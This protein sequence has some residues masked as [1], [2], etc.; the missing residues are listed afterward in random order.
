MGAE[1]S[2]CRGNPLL[3]HGL[4]LAIARAFAL[5]LVLALARAAEAGAAAALRK[6]VR[7][8]LRREDLEQSATATSKRSHVKQSPNCC[9]GNRRIT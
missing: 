1:Q 7:R 3:L 8:H 9:F 2:R 5:A 4:A 6:D